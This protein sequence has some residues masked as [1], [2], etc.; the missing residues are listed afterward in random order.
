VVVI[1]PVFK[2]A[3]DEEE[4]TKEEEEE[5]GNECE[6]EATLKE[7]KE[8]PEEVAE[9]ANWPFPIVESV[10]QSEDDGIGWA[11]GVDGCP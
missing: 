5:G 2:E 11:D 6:F 4:E 10:V 7:G 9:I 1:E 8:T 3:V